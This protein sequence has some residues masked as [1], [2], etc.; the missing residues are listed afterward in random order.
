MKQNLISYYASIDNK[1][2]F[3]CLLVKRCG[4]SLF[5]IRKWCMGDGTTKNPKCLEVLHE[6]TGIAIPDLFNRDLD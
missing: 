4:I 3:G 2:A 6:L 5:S 1:T